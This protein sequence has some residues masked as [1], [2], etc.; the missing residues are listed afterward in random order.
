MYQNVETVQGVEMVME[1]I[2]PKW[3]DEQQKSEHQDCPLGSAHIGAAFRVARTDKGLSLAD[4]ASEIHIKTA[5][6][7]GIE[8]LDKTALPSL[9]YVLGFVRT[10]ALHLGMNAQDAVT[11]YKIDIECP[12]NMGMRD[13]PHYVPKRKIRLPKGSF[14]AGMVLSCMLVVVTWYGWKADAHS[15]PTTTQIPEARNWGFE[16]LQPTQNDPD[17]I[18]LKAVG[19][20]FV[21]VTDKDGTTLIS[22]IMVPGEIFETK[23]QNGPLLSLRDAGAIELYIGGARIG[24]IGQKGESAKNI[25]LA[26]AAQ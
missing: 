2:V 19:P 14:A 6:L 1:T 26:T 7:D 24:V 16:D 23:R 5:Y 22:R 20:S 11:R 10:Y 21:Q 12:Q 17:M 3:Q 15:A 4:I 13:R 25:P 9:G 8:R 18:S